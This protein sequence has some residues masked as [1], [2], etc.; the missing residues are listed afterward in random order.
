M[1]PQLRNDVLFNNVSEPMIGGQ[2]LLA[3]KCGRCHRFS[4]ASSRLEGDNFIWSGVRD[5]FISC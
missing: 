5:V 2:L 1:S 3:M 4:N